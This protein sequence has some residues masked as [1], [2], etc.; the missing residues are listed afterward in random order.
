VVGIL[1]ER[2]PARRRNFCEAFTD[3][4][5]LWM[6]AHPDVLSPTRGRRGVTSLTAITIDTCRRPR[7]TLIGVVS[8]RDLM[9][10]ARIRPAVEST[11]TCRRIGGRGR[12]ETTV[13][14]VRGQEGFFHY[15]QYSAVDLAGSVRWKTCGTSC[16]GGTSDRAASAT[17][18][19][20]YGATGNCRGLASL[21]PALARR[22]APLE[23]LRSAVSVLGRSSLASDHDLDAD[24]LF[25]QAMPV[26]RRPD[27]SAAA[28]ASPTG[29][30]SS[31]P[32]RPRFAQLPVHAHRRRASP[33]HSRPSSST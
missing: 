2:T 10:M 27:D 13:G 32:G 31:S 20:E 30:L 14:D 18:S 29:S 7:D 15:R 23:V 28:I 3:G 12:G 1:T 22:G 19:A 5:A 11:T 25:E 6:T 16:S 21:L 33:M 24:E 8:L 4:V 17:F 26:R 9:G